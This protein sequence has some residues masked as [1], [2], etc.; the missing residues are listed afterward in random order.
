M[1]RH[2]AVTVRGGPAQADVHGDGRMPGV[3]GGRAGSILSAGETKQ[4]AVP[5]ART[6]PDP[7]PDPQ[8]AP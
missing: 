7:A 1:N 8:E 2:N 5:P 6:Q 3:R 4:Q